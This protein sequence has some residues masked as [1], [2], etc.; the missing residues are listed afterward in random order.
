[1]EPITDSDAVTVINSDLNKRGNI[2]R[3]QWCLL[4]SLYITP[5]LGVGFFLTA[6]VAILRKSG[7]SLETVSVVYLLGLVWAL[8]F[9]W[10]PLVDRWKSSRLGH[11][12]AWL[13]AMQTLMIISLLLIGCFDPVRE[14]STVYAL[15]LL[16]SLAAA[17]Q[18]IAVNGLAY[19]LAPAHDR[20]QVNGLQAAGGLLGN[21]LGAGAVLMAYPHL[22][23]TGCTLLLAAGCSVSLTQSFFFKEPEFYNIPSG[24]SAPVFKQLRSLF[25]RHGQR[26]WLFMILLYPLGVSMGYA[27]ITP[28]LVDSGWELDRIGLVVNVVG[29]LCGIPAALLTGRFIRRYG[30]RPVLLGAALLQVPGILILLLPLGGATGVLP[31]LLAVGLFFFCYNPAFAVLTTLM[32]DHAAPNSPAS[33]YASQY[34]LYMLFSIISVTIGTAA[35]GRVGY[36]AVLAT[37]AACALLMAPFA[38]SYRLQEPDKSSSDPQTTVPIELFSS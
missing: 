34:S 19:R 30:R 32:M 20:G 10:A 21:M 35:A 8:K 28:I 33:D 29:S 7:A 18:N 24:L 31:V 1:M 6:L 12:R 4:G 37:A 3:A 23:W 26:R 17:T 25:L 5:Y 11:F 14:F 36:Q 38:W 27:L 15:C 22:G 16:L 13:L 9:I 2:S